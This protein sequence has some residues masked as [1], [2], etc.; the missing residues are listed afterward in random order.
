[1]PTTYYTEEE[2]NF[3]AFLT[4]AFWERCHQ[5]YETQPNKDYY[6]CIPMSLEIVSQQ[7]KFVKKYILD[8]TK[9][10]IYDKTFLDVGC[11]L[12]HILL[13]AGVVQFQT[14]G[15]E[16]N[17]KALPVWARTKIDFSKLEKGF[18][19]RNY[20]REVFFLGDALDFPLY[21]KF[22]VIYFYIPIQNNKLML[23]L[24]DKIIHD[25]KEGSI[26]IA[27]GYYHDQMEKYHLKELANHIYQK[28][29]EEG[30]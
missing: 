14:F 18:D 20:S 5:G 3:M 12:G 17:P 29:K 27:N 2:Y 23:K 25:M 7:I 4:K 6:P 13:A 19:F 16:V 1:M 10:Y 30:K 9:D 22:D 28:P 24:S 21:S 15:I 8:T 26:L 11:G